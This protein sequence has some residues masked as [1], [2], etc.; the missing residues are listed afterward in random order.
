MRIIY[1]G[2]N[3]AGLRVLEWLVAQGDE[4]AALV[5]H[6]PEKSRYRDEI[7]AAARLPAVRVFDGPQLRDPST[8]ETLSALRPEIGLSVFFGYIFRQ[9]VLSLF[10]AGCLNLHSSYLPYNRGAYA[11]VWSIVDRTP[12]GVTLHYVD[13]GVDTGDIV[14]Q[15]Q[16]PVLA[17]DTGKALYARL[18]EACAELFKVT[19][20]LVRS[21][22]AP[23]FPQDRSRATHHRVADVERI[24]RI[25]LDRTYT[26]RDLLDIIR[27]RTFP[28]FKGAYFE[29]AGERV[30]MS[31]ELHRDEEIGR[32]DHQ[33]G[34]ADAR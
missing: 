13:A 9:D 32:L 14:A 3:L 17:T 33:E 6:P 15:R 22:R 24:D 34:G 20:P 4:V 18:E 30:Y 19:W 21:G 28:P 23:R 26:A 7:I 25:D 8:I 31:L 10:P 27:A 11:N 2:N 16:V 1:F 12:A 29:E 5:V